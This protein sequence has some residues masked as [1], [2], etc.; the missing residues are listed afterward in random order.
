MSR[1]GFFFSFLVS[2]ET[3]YN[4]QTMQMMIC[5]SAWAFATMPTVCSVTS[6]AVY[7]WRGCCQTRSRVLMCSAPFATVHA[8]GYVRMHVQSCKL[9][10]AW[11]A[12]V[13]GWAAMPV[14]SPRFIT[15]T[16]LHG[17]AE[18]GAHAPSPG[19]KVSEHEPIP[20]LRGCVILWGGTEHEMAR[21]M[22]ARGAGLPPSRQPAHLPWQRLARQRLCLPC[23]SPCQPCP[24]PGGNGFIPFGGKQITSPVL[25]SP[26]FYYPAP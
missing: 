12:P 22:G 26:V 10:V 16:S 14:R 6:F 8:E 7:S 25:G 13:H 20:R 1:F 15:H 21:A 5:F 19:G 24:C 23:A 18:H 2:I 4:I 11:R 3:S 9:S 17:T